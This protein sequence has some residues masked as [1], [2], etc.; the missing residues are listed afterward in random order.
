M[1]VISNERIKHA[2]Q[3]SVNYVVNALAEQIS[4]TQTEA[5]R[6][7]VQSKTYTLLCAEESKLYTESF[8]YVLD[9]Y[10]SE[11]CGDMENWMAQ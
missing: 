5:Y 8:E 2:M 1:T 7:F 9:M 4:I 3:L 6:R 11:L 10:S